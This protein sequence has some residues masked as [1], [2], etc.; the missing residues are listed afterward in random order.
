MAGIELATAY[1]SIVPSAK[2][3]QGKLAAEMG[4]AAPVATAAGHKAGKGF[5]GGM[6]SQLKHSAGMIGLAIGAS[7]IEHF[8]HAGVEAAEDFHRTELLTAAA[9]KSTGQAAGVS[10]EHIDQLSTSLGKTDAVSRKS[11]M[12]IDNMLLRFTQIKNSGPDKIFDRATAAILDLS[13]ATGRDGVSAARML[14]KA[15]NDPVTQV[16][17]LTRAGV[18]FT[19][20]QKK[21]IKAVAESGDLLGAQSMILDGVTKSYGGSAAA[22][23]TPTQRLKVGFASFRTGIGKTILPVVEE[24]AGALNDHLIPALKTVPETIK[25]NW[26]LIAPTL[27]TVGAA[28]VELWGAVVDLWN[29]LQPVGLLIGG[30]FLVAIRLAAPAVEALAGGIHK[31]T[32]ALSGQAPIIQAVI[33]AILAMWGAMKLYGIIRLVMGAFQAFGQFLLVTLGRAA[34]AVEAFG[35]MA[36]AALGVVGIAIGIAVYLWQRNASAVRKAKEAAAEHKAVVEDLTHAIEADNGALGE[37]TRLTT[38]DALK[39]NGAVDAARRLGL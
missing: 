2:G 22:L 32:G 34:L 5:L 1:V 6:S 9:I 18:A 29:I 11:I 33:A 4:G 21:Q 20:E 28:F 26:G 30:V 36:S 39:K 16:G 19:A 13:A 31:L 27:D 24:V 12:Q 10:A 38:F 14:G 7:A 17:S 3:I 25:T 35:A 23:A 8:F 37:S 15:L